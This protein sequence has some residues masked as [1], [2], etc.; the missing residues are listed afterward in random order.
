[1]QFQIFIGR[2]SISRLRANAKRHR[3]NEEV[4]CNRGFAVTFCRRQVFQVLQ[5]SRLQEE[6][7]LRRSI[8]IQGIVIA[9][10][11]VSTRRAFKNGSGIIKPSVQIFFIGKRFRSPRKPRITGR[12]QV[13]QEF[14]VGVFF[15]QS[16]DIRSKLYNPR[17]P[18]QA[19]GM[20]NRFIIVKAYEAVVFNQLVCHRHNRH[21]I[22]RN[23]DEDFNIQ[24]FAKVHRFKHLCATKR[25]NVLPHHEHIVEAAFLVFHKLF[26]S[27]FRCKPTVENQLIRLHR[28]VVRKLNFFETAIRRATTKQP[29]NHRT[30][31]CGKRKSQRQKYTK[32]SFHHP[33]N[34]PADILFIIV[35][36]KQQN[37]NN[38]TPVV[39]VI[40]AKTYGMLVL[41]FV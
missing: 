15:V 13:Y 35:L 38:T 33:F 2:Y 30:A 11:P 21:I 25:A 32:F 41:Y 18:V 8:T 4:G 12:V 31:S 39:N 17:R 28:I 5:P 9:R 34:P 16:F 14:Y 6:F 22:T 29:F 36:L 40:A 23:V 10:Q 26:S 20:D 3:L 7:R 1:M 37:T 24:L 27:N 19:A